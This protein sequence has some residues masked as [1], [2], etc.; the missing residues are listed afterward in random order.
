M[1]VYEITGGRPLAG[2]LTVQGAKNSVL[3]ILAAAVLADGESVIH[4]CPNLS[5]VSATLDIL[6]LLGCRVAREGD[7]VRIDASTLGDSRI[8]DQLMGEMRSS[9]VFLG[10][11]LARC[12]GAELSY[13]GGCELGPRPIDLHLTALRAL[14]AEVR[15][16]GGHLLCRSGR[17]MAGRELCLSIPSVGA[18]ENAILAACGCPGLTTIVGAAREPEIED[19]QAFLRSMGGQVEGAGTSVVR[20]LGGKRLHPAEHTVI[21]DRMAAATYLCAVGAAGGCVC[22]KGVE[23]GCL[24]AV[25]SVLKE[26]GADVQ[27]EGDTL[28]IACAAPLCGVRTVRTAPHPGFPTDAQAPLMAAM[29]C[30]TGTTMFVENMFLNRYRHV[31]ELARMGADIQVDG[32]VAVVTG[33]PL[34]AAQV[35]G[36]DLRGSA[37][38][39]VAALGAQGKSQVSGVRHILRGYQSLDGDLRALGAQIEKKELP[40][41]TH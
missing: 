30:G 37:A 28:S 5:D 31:G 10:A 7:T 17:G 29:S 22:L 38:L 27:G 1:C 9:V 26:A 20:V 3:P 16:E 33:R 6:R 2:Q 25:L 12:G 24:T 4:N 35:R 36:T 40:A 13:P 15:E 21:G 39:V 14:G 18:T 23:S 11:L 19:L 8:P 32:R 34:H 41:G